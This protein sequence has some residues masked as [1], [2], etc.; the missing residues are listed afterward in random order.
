MSFG[1]CFWGSWKAAKTVTILVKRVRAFQ[2]PACVHIISK[3]H[4]LTSS[5]MPQSF[6]VFTLHY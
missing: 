6:E 3:G 1:L 4:A 2:S 5:R